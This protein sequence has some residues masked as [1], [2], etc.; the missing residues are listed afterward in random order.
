M[1]Q[2]KLSVKFKLE[3][4]IFYPI[5]VYL[6]LFTV[7]Y[8]VLNFT[9][10]VLPSDPYDFQVTQIYTSIDAMDL[11]LICESNIPKPSWWVLGRCGSLLTNRI[12]I[13]HGLVCLNRQCWWI[14]YRTFSLFMAVVPQ[15]RVPKFFYWVSTFTTS[16]TLILIFLFHK[17][18]WIFIKFTASWNYSFLH[19]Q[20]D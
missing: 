10:T 18:V 13:Q 5:F 12:I 19:L 17:T 2:K 15:S 9:Y 1:K 14:K 20:L 7:S 16:K 8:F 6:P 4:K 11:L 3:P